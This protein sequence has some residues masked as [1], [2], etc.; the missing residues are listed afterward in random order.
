GTIQVATIDTQMLREA[1]AGGSQFEQ[2]KMRTLLL[3]FFRYAQPNGA[4]ASHLANPVDDLFVDQV[5]HKQRHRMTIEQF[6]AIHRIAPQ[7]L[8]WLMTLGFHLALR[9]VDLVNLRFS[10]VVDG[11]IISPI[12]K[13]D[14]EARELEEASVD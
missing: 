12:R 4:F 10:D 9:R 7:G 2:D 13:T 5:P 11:R 3:C 1:I 8:Q 6:K 14:T